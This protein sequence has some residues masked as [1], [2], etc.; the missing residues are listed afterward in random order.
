MHKSSSFGYMPRG[1]NNKIFTPKS[2][3]MLGS[4]KDAEVAYQEL[5]GKVESLGIY[6]WLEN[7]K[8][9]FHDRYPEYD[10]V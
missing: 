9:E 2:W 6:S 5:I 1:R 10:S 3:V 8:R 7:R 4:E